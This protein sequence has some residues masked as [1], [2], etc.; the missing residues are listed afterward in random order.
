MESFY[1]DYNY[2]EEEEE[3]EEAPQRPRAAHKG[4]GSIMH[5]IYS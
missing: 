5:N 2:W 4:A 3:E 1:N